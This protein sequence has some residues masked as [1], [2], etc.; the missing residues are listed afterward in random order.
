M[1]WPN[2]W[3]S[4]CHLFFTWQYS[5]YSLAISFILTPFRFEQFY[6]QF[7]HP[8][9]SLILQLCISHLPLYSHS[10]LTYLPEMYPSSF[11]RAEYIIVPVQDPMT[12]L[13][14]LQNNHMLVDEGLPNY[15]MSCA[16]A[17]QIHRLILAWEIPP[18]I[19]S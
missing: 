6:Q 4:T 5:F 15:L 9:P 7:Y 2:L 19:S 3:N 8:C 17:F 10:L 12:L 14:I 11:V 1:E 16:L 13:D 18:P